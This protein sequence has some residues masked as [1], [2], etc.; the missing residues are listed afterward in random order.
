MIDALI[1]NPDGDWDRAAAAELWGSQGIDF[2]RAVGK[3]RVTRPISHL[4]GYA[5]NLAGRIET[6]TAEQEGRIQASNE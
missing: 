2:R 3:E 4:G 6:L 1:E 5:C